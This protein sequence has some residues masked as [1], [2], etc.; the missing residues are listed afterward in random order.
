MRARLV[1]LSIALALSSAFVVGQGG[2]PPRQQKRSPAATTAKLDAHDLS[3]IWEIHGH[4]SIG[5]DVPPMTPE[6]KARFDAN[7]PTRGR[8]LGEPLNGD[9]PGFVR[10]QRFPADGNDPSHTCNPDGFPR[11]LLDPE[12]VEF[13]QLK[14]RMLQM[15]QWG[16]TH[17][18]IWIDGRELPSG[19]N[20]ENLGPAWFGHSVGEW[21]GDTLVVNTVGLDDRAWIDI[22]GFPKSFYAR[23]EERYR[24][25]DAD[26][27]E[28]R[29]TMYD[30][31]F[32]TTPWESDVKTWKRVP[33]KEVT[34]FGWYGLYAGVTEGSC[35]PLDEVEDYNKTFRNLG[36]TQK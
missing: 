29:M 2:Q 30:P 11:L 18:E 15:F 32:Y 35:A 7:K 34:Y 25:I 31:K 26:T 6:G 8:F 4:R 16:H 1:T 23:I 14:D 24:R 12:P 33:R 28:L 17:R 22:F 27:I 20:L 36:S 5:A 10:A 13:I 19:E 3:G 9:H 21:R